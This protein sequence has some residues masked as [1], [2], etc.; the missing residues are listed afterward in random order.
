MRDEGSERTIAMS[1][2]YLYSEEIFTLTIY[3]WFIFARSITDDLEVDI[4][5]PLQS[6][7]AP[8]HIICGAV[9]AHPG[10]LNYPSIGQAPEGVDDSRAPPG[11]DGRCWG[12]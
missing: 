4:E 9:R 10:F 12:H 5:S 6:P 3:L 7:A 1:L 11:A 8:S 2:F